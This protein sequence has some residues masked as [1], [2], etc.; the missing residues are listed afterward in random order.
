MQKPYLGERA[1]EAIVYT[2]VIGGCIYLGALTY[3]RLTLNN[4]NISAV[5]VKEF[6]PRLESAT[7]R[8][9]VLLTGDS[10]IVLK[11][12]DIRRW[13]EYYTRDYT[14]KKDAR[15]SSSLIMNYLESVALQ[16]DTDPVNA[17]LKF[18]NDRAKIFVPSAPGK[19][20]NL[21]YSAQIISAAIIDNKPSVSMAFDVLEP[22]ITLDRINDLGISTLLGFG[23]SDYGKS[24]AARINNIK[25]GLSKF[26]GIILKP[27]E[28]FSFNKIL[29][30][31]D[32]TGGYK[33]ELV[34]KSGRLVKEFGGGLCQVATTMFRAAILSGLEI[35]ERRPHSFSVQY[36]NPQGFDATIYPGVVDLRFVNNTRNHILIQARLLGSQPLIEIYG[37]SNG[38]RVVMDGP[39][40]YDKQPSGAMKAYFTRKIYQGEQLVKEERFNSVYKAPPPHPIERNPLE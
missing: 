21:S 17:K 34:I 36:Y 32:E 12:T 30:T 6:A 40:S 23:T 22:E 15:I 2:L 14:G 11:D 7:H 38:E 28:E 35:E 5:A 26:N 20:L 9:L 8:N 39:H 31:V 19:K 33:A 24:S 29:G 13:I 18:E 1:I 25:V 16:F 3:P 27:G 37:T 10:E 4:T